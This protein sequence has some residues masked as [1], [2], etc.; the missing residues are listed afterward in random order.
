MSNEVKK[1]IVNTNNGD[2]AS[3]A[4]QL[5]DEAGRPGDRD[6]EFWLQAEKEVAASLV[7]GPAVPAGG[8]KPSPGSFT[9]PASA[10]S[11][12]MRRV[13]QT[14]FKANRSRATP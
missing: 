9:K 6:L 11:P 14:R 4:Y 12:T 3:R 7:K 2:I 8:L 1:G 10:F 13:E 5:W